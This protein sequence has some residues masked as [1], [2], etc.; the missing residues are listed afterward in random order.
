M[1]VLPYITCG[2]AAVPKA[3]GSWQ[4]SDVSLAGIG[5][6]LLVAAPCLL[7]IAGACLEHGPELSMRCM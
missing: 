7:H 5:H 6:L 4:L 2:F 3:F 1:N